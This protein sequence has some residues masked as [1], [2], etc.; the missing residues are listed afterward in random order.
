MKISARTD[1][2]QKR[3]MN[4][5]CYNFGKVEGCNI[6]WAVVCDGMGGMAAG[7]V[8]SELVVDVISRSY[9]DNL[10]SKSSPSFINNLIKNSVNAANAAVYDMSKSKPSLKGMGTTVVTVVVLDSVAYFAHAGDSR[11]YL[12]Q[13]GEL[14]QVTTDHSIVQS[15]VETGQITEDEAKNHPN[16]NIITRA[17]GV[18][19]N[20]DVDFETAQLCPNDIIL[21]CTDGLTNC[22]DHETI[23]KTVKESKFKDIS[24]HLVNIANKNGGSDNITVVALCS[25]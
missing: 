15:M 6:C 12:Y 23:F 11:A 19:C 17:V 13:N 18:N 25:E 3:Q 9:S 21:L 2:G 22:V 16:K 4:Q 10:N 20:L 24:E 14:T 1:I 7:N 5:D 8:A